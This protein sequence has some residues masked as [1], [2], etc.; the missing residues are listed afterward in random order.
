MT[1]GRHTAAHLLCAWARNTIFDVM[2]P[3]ALVSQHTLLQRG[4]VRESEE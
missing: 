2:R 4:P 1:T 3:A